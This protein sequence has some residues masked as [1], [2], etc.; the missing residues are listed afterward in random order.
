[1]GVRGEGVGGRESGKKDRKRNNEKGDSG[2]D[3]RE[4][5]RGKRCSFNSTLK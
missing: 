3:Q 1:M 5:E 2:G 4:R